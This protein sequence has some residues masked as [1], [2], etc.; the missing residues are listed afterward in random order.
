[1]LLQRQPTHRNR[2]E[3]EDRNGDGEIEIETEMLGSLVIE[4]EIEW[5]S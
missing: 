4:E 3:N 2:D 1:M 5:E